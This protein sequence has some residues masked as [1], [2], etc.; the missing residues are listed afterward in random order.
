MPATSPTPPPSRARCPSTRRPP[1]RLTARGVTQATTP[2]GLVGG[3]EAAAG[4]PLYQPQTIPGHIAG[5]AAEW[6]T[7]AAIGPL[8]GLPTAIA[9][10]AAGGGASGGL[11]QYLASRGYA[12]DS[13]QRTI[14]PTA[15]G[16][17]T[18]VGLGILAKNLF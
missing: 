7:G 11:D 8:R 10:G 2:S 3:A 17:L 13:W 5:S 4:G 18:T 6:G 1:T 12:P 14:L 16:V 15:A 9:L